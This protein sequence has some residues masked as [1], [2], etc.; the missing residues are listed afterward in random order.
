M[1]GYGVVDPVNGGLDLLS[2]RLDV[3][4]AVDECRPSSDE[5]YA[6]SVDEVDDRSEG[7]PHSGDHGDL[8][9]VV[10][11]GSAFELRMAVEKLEQ[12]LR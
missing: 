1:A 10:D 2:R 8:T 7:D 11:G 9:K 6:G 12:P 5:V 3:R 4:T